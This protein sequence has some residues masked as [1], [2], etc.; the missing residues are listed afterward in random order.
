MLRFSSVFRASLLCGTIASGPALAA[1]TFS[2]VVILSV[3]GLHQA[4]LTDPATR[5]YLPNIV[6]LTQTGVTYSNVTGSQPSDSFP[7]TAAL[8]TGASPRTT[9]VFYDDSYVRNYTAPG[10][11]AATPKDTEAQYAENIDKNQLLLSGGGP[12][13][14]PGAYGAGAIDPAK[15][16]LN[17]TTGTC[18]PVTPNLLLKTNTIFDVA[19]QAGLTSGFSDKHPAA[20]TLFAGATGKSITDNYSPEINSSVALDNGK[21]IDASNNP[22]N[23]PLVDSTRNYKLTQ[24]Y[25]DLK[26]AATINRIDGKTGLG[27]ATAA[28]PAIMYQNFQAVSVAQKLVSN[29]TGTGG[30]SIVNGQEVVSPALADS[31]AHTD[32]SVG[33]IKAELAAKGL[34]SSTLLILTAKHGQDPRIGAATQV[35][36][37][38]IPDALTAAGIGVAQATQDDVALLWL[39]DPSQAAAAKA[40]ILGLPSAD[41]VDSVLDGSL[42]GNPLT[43]NRTPDLIVKVKAGF[44]YDGNTASTVK[45]AEHG[46]LVPDDLNVPLI[47]SSTGLDLAVQGTTVNSPVTTTQVAPSVLAALGLNPNQLDGVRAEGTQVLAGADLAVPEPASLVLLGTAMLGLAAKRRRTDR[48]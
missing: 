40:I 22:K 3:D 27:D 36:D 30:I 46:G 8:L 6:G 19:A 48:A 42:F 10:G 31:L 43:D 9:G 15:L 17:C 24:A 18:T 14:G 5:A 12:T 21:L 20:Y 34:A 4:D 16:V 41:G 32:A 37:S 23:L 38:T 47:L 35:S 44:L 13:S 45:R 26:V 2:H 1:N 11:T 29:A 39:I 25:D 28:T 7:G 33:A